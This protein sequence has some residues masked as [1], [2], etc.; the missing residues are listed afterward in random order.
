MSDVLVRDDPGLDDLVRKIVARANPAEIWLFG[1]RARGDHHRDSDYDLL[2]VVDDDW[3]QVRV[4][5]RE[6]YNL[7][8]GR[9]IPVDPVMIRK[10][11]FEEKKR[12][13]GTLSHEVACDGK[14]LYARSRTRALA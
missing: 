8:E 6:A 11:R 3:P 2:I 9:Q 5:A 1:S 13:I 10:S 4:N 12:L 14:L 7:V